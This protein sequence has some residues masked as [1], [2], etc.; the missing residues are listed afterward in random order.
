MRAKVEHLE[1]LVLHLRGCSTS[2]DQL[3]TACARRQRNDEA[4]MV[5]T[6]ILKVKSLSQPAGNTHHMSSSHWEAIMERVSLRC[7]RRDK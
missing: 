6:P 7:V 5:V 2:S 1:K 3:V 4:G